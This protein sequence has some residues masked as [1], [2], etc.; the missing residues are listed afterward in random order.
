[1]TVMQICSATGC[2]VIGL[3]ETR[4]AGQGSIA[5]DGYV[6]IWSGARAGT[7]DKRGVHGVGIAIKEAMWESVGEE[8]RTVECIS[9]RLMKVR[10][11]IGH[12]C[13]V[14]FVVGYAPT[15]TVR[16]TAGGNVKAKDSFWTALDAAIREVHSRVHLV[17]LMD[18]DA[19]IGRRRDGCCDVKIMGAYGRDIMNNNAERVLGLA[20][21][22]QLSLTNTYFRTPKGG[23]Q[24][25]FQSSNKGK[26]KYRLDF[27]LMRQTDRRFV[28]WYMSEAQHE[29]SEASKEIKAAQQQLRGASKNSAFE[30]TLKAM[31][32][33]ARKK[34]SIAR[35]RA[36]ETFFEGYVRQLEKKSREGDQAGF[37]RH[38][39]MIDVE[40]KRSFTS[41]NIKDEDGKVLRDPTFIRQRWA[42]WFHKLLNTKSPTIDLHAADKV[43]RWPT[44]VPLDHIPSLLE[45]EEAVREM[46]NSKTVGPD[47]LPAELIKLFLDGGQGLLREFH[48]TVVDV[49]QAGDVPQQ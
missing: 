30:A 2:D 48:A 1:M 14:T 22:N 10:M 5:H 40:G 20:S 17:V 18:A 39:K 27:I 31:L 24:H 34:R 9:P 13:V 4:R 16:T 33:A 7:K 25:T 6:I 29:I 15:E 12:T 8:G 46:V 3:Q 41:Q 38:L 42:R 28:R 23:V 36:L 35:W 47:D 32:K 44:C 43:K 26:E 45:V 21:D 11:Q 49:W 19:R 37:Y